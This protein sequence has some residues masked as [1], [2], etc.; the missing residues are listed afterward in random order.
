[1]TVD[2]TIKSFEC[3]SHSGKTCKECP[4]YEYISDC[5]NILHF[6]AKEHLINQRKEIKKLKR[7]LKNL[8]I[9]RC[10][11]C[12]HLKYDRDFTTGRYCS[13]R[14]VNGGKYCKDDDFCSYGAR[15]DCD[16]R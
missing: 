14:N 6:N 7:E 12:K 4:L 1:M 3:C 15:M 2:E 10:K 16:K 9:V 11:D 5:H 13:L 8:E